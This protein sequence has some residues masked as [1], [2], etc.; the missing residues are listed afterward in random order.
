MLPAS[1]DKGIVN[2]ENYQ[3]KGRFMGLLKDKDR[4][5]ITERL[6]PMDGKVKLVFFTQELECDFCRDTHNLL[7]EVVELSDKLEMEVYNLLTDAETAAKFKVEKVP[8]L[9]LVDENDTDFGIRYYGIPSGY[10]FASLLDDILMIS[11]GDSG[12]SESIRETLKS[13]RGNVHLQVFVTPTCP[14][15]PGAVRIA[16]QM[17]YESEKLPQIWSRRLNFRIYQTGTMSVAS[18]GRLSMKIRHWKECAPRGCSL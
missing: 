12:L 11:E 6:K 5:A 1:Y 8:A 15:C 9:A 16:H 10:E 17:A 14:Y 3:L 18:Q 2:Y 4:E 7:S 13:L